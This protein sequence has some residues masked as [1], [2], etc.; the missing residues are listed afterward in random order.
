MPPSSNQKPAENQKM[1]SFV[2]LRVKSAYSLLEGAVRPDE[3]AELARESAMPAVAVTDVNNLFG[4]FEIVE[5]ITQKEKEHRS[6]QKIPL[7]P[8]Q[9][10]VGALLSVE[11]GPASAAPGSISLLSPRTLLEQ[12]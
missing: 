4:V 6:G 12:N 11:L 5:K 10:M 2:Q 8:V 9:P 7:P 1:A 3:L